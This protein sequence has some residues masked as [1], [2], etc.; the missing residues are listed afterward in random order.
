MKKIRSFYLISNKI[1]AKYVD[2]ILKN[3]KRFLKI[4]SIAE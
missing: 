4:I 1:G 3:P 2:A